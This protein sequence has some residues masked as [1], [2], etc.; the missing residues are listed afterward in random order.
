MRYILLVLLAFVTTFASAQVQFLGSPTTTVR[1]R[2]NFVSDSLFYL[3]KRQVAPTD[4]AAMRYAI[5]DSSVYVWTGRAWRSIGRA[6]ASFLSVS[7]TSSMLSP[8]IRAAGNGL[9]K[10]GQSLLVD[11][12]TIA[13]RA[14]VQNAVDSINTNVALKVNISDTSSMLTPYTRGSG[15]TNYL[16]KFTGTRTFGNSQLFDNGTN[17]G[18]STSNPM[19]KL[20]VQGI[21]NSSTSYRLANNA[22]TQVALIDNNVGGFI[23]GYNLTLSGTTPQHVAT[24]AMSGY[25]VDDIG[26]RFF[27]NT[28]QS[29]GT[30]ASER[31]RITST[32]DI[33]IG[34]TTSGNVGIGTS[35]IHGKVA[36]NGNT[37]TLSITNTTTAANGNTAILG[38]NPVSAFYNASFYDKGP[39]VRGLLEDVSTNRSALTF[40]TY[41]GSGSVEGM[42]VTSSQEVLVNTTTDA[43]AYALQVAGSI[44]NTTGAVLAA[45]SGSIGIGTTSTAYKLNIS[46]SV[47]VS[48][49]GNGYVFGLTDANTRITGDNSGGANTYIEMRTNGANRLRI[50]EDG[51]ILLNNISDAGAYT[52]QVAGAIYNT[53]TITTGAPTG[54]SIKPWRLGEAATVSPTSPNRTIRV[55][56]DGTVYYIHAKTTND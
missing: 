26:M 23:S 32:G 37:P 31:M 21:V 49:G 41:N 20:D 15:T 29:A 34:T 5:S 33:T 50:Q 39:S 6:G 17:V 48:G 14:R 9:T 22:Y 54:G 12:A 16:P 3:P 10:S 11:T 46:G 18:I 45:S 19:A 30:T 2:G 4:T 35:T 43:G 52:L 13:T 8:Y 38:L 28:S 53:T 24:G 55:E 47:G 56:I 51:E 25:M 36:V 42:R 44:Y 40:H 27:S 1:N 7:D